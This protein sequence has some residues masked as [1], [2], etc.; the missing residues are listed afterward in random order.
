MGDDSSSHA[1]PGPPRPR[2][3]RRAHGGQPPRHLHPPRR[4]GPGVSTH[5]ACASP[6]PNQP[7]PPPQGGPP[8]IWTPPEIPFIPP[9]HPQGPQ[10]CCRWL[11]QGGLQETLPPG[12]CLGGWGGVCLDAWVVPPQ[13]SCVPPQP[14]CPPP[15][16][17][18]GAHN[19]AEPLCVL[20]FYIHESLQRHGYGRELFQHMLQVTKRDKKGGREAGGRTERD[21][22]DSP[23]PRASLF[24]PPVAE[25]EGGSLAFGC[26][27]TL[28][29]APGFSPQTLRPH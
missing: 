9:P 15:Q 29:E 28:R 22:G 27:P 6:P 3:Q 19:E 20:D 25:R 13:P 24:P 7:L 18:N 14:S 21:I 10:R 12:E 23:S 2:H 5:N 1:G 16:D 17:R 11:S 4:R 8:S 26:R